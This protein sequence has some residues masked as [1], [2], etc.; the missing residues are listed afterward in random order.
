ML[1]RKMHGWGCSL[2]HLRFQHTINSTVQPSFLHVG[3]HP[4]LGLQSLQ[5]G[6]SSASIFVEG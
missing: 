2:L 5:K 1:L 4:S 3:K 6:F